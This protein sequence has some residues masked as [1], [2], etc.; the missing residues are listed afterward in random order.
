MLLQALKTR[1]KLGCPTRIFPPE[2]MPD[3]YSGIPHLC[4]AMSDAWSEAVESCPT[5]SLTIDS[6][7]PLIDIGK[8]IF[9]KQCQ[10]IC[11]PEAIRFTGEY[12]QAVFERKD[13]IYRQSFSRSREI[14]RREIYRT[15]RRSLKLRHIS[16]GGC[17]A[18][19]SELILANWNWDISRFGIQI[20][21]SPKHA[22]GL[23]ITGPVTSSM[24]KSLRQTYDAIGLPKV[25]IAVGTCAISG[26]IYADHTETNS[27]IRRLIP[28]DL[29]I[30]G[31]PPHPATILDGMLR[32]MG[33]IK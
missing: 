3:Q 10:N 26:G 18:C 29:Y 12:R 15:F 8:C 7:E 28:V 23:L 13:L 20:V 21:N 2:S 9:C 4:P 25:V 16:A 24:R 19:E 6:G 32:L 17:N 30:P 27:G 22:D 33:R 14:L 11:G 5:G 1:F 31:C